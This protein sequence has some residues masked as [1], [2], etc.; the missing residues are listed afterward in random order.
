MD[1]V[2]K[3]WEAESPQLLLQSFLYEATRHGKAL[4]SPQDSCSLRLSGCCKDTAAILEGCCDAQAVQLIIS[5]QL[6]VGGVEGLGSRALV[7]LKERV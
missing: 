6:C 1:S 3:E 7:R 4:P 2:L 5:D